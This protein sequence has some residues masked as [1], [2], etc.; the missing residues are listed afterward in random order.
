MNKPRHALRL[1]RGR[2]SRGAFNRSL[3]Q[4]QKN[5]IRSIYTL[6]LL[7]YAGLF[8]SPKLEPFIDA[9]DQIRTFVENR[10]SRGETP[11]KDTIAL[12][13]SSLTSTM[14]DLAGRKSFLER[15]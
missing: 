10:R 15:M 12:L 5:I 4:A 8:D 11:S 6:F 2:I 7:G 14:G 3:I 1:G 13:T 9:A